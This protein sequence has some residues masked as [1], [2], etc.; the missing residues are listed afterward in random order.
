MQIQNGSTVLARAEIIIIMGSN[1]IDKGWR[2][3]KR[4]QITMGWWE[5]RL[6]PLSF[7]VSSW[8]SLYPSFIWKF[9]YYLYVKQ[10]SDCFS[11]GVVWCVATTF[12]QY[13]YLYACINPLLLGWLTEWHC[14]LSLKPFDFSCTSWLLLISVTH[15]SLAGV[16]LLMMTMRMRGRQW[17]VLFYATHLCTRGMHDVYWNC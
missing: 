15:I 9:T 11:C 17:M 8:S 1:R 7:W 13:A 3:K 2:P 5:K 14:S 10:I 12:N 6:L 4:W 16:E